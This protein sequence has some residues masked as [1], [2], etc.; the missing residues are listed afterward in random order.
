M[1]TQVPWGEGHVPP[2]I[3]ALMV[4]HRAAAQPETGPD[5]SGGGS[6]SGAISALTTWHG[7]GAWS[8]PVPGKWEQQPCRVVNPTVN[9]YTSPL[10]GDQG[11]GYPR[12]RDRAC[13]CPICSLVVV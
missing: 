7:A 3:S 6:I 2:Q 12:V 9:T 11:Q 8:E 1:G 10:H 13:P 4:G 5:S